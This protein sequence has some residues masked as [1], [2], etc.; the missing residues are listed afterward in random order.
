M[1]TV[2]LTTEFG[3][4]NFEDIMP[5]EQGLPV[6]TGAEEDYY[7][8]QDYE[9]E[10]EFE[11]DF[12][13][14]QESDFEAEMKKVVEIMKIAGDDLSAN[15][16][17]TMVTDLVTKAREESRSREEQIAK[18]KM[19]TNL[20]QMFRASNAQRATESFLQ[21]KPTVNPVREQ[22]E[23][24]AENFNAQG[25]KDFSQILLEKAKNRPKNADDFGEVNFELPKRNQRPRL[26]MKQKDLSSI[27]IDKAK[28]RPAFVKDF[29]SGLQVPVFSTTTRRPSLV[30]QDLSHILINKAK[31]RPV[32]VKDF[33]SGLEVPVIFS[34]TRRPS[35]EEQDLSHILIDKAKNRPEF[36]K[37]FDT[38]LQVPVFSTTRRPSVEENLSQED[39]SQI[40]I[41]KAKNKPEVVKDFDSGLRVPVVNEFPATT[42]NP[43]FSQILIEK[44][45]TRPK[46]V[47]DFDSGLELPLRPRNLTEILD[48]PSSKEM[49]EDHI[50]EMIIENPERA[51]ADLAELFDLKDE[52]E[53]NDTEEELFEMME[54]DPLAVT[55]AFT[56][57][58]LAQKNRPIATTVQTLV[59][60]TEAFEPV[61]IEDV[62]EAVR[63]QM[64]RMTK[65]PE[66][67]DEEVSVQIGDSNLQVSP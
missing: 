62:P 61:K 24:V 23:E 47:K 52:N 33:D 51:A 18:V 40:L 19:V 64:M 21:R 66:A 36:V 13:I 25:Q 41:N 59:P 46:K 28:T 9:E 39:L 1:D 67:K 65:K 42:A 11:P 48:M 5:T 32:K 57:L 35:L 38:G 30:E 15:T 10:V 2:E 49:I 4:L 44:A 6:T 29:D 60:T 12:E 20:V 34:T 56:D 55:S 37:D 8:E 27:L 17:K 58:I 45:K 31:T 3:T 54:K 43:D 22:L 16:I 63:G 50:M 7:E 53:K 26:H 14:E